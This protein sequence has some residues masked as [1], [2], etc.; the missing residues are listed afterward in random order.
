MSV[1]HPIVMIDTHNVSAV[2]PRASVKSFSI[3]Q[4]RQRRSCAAPMYVLVPRLLW[5]E[6]LEVFTSTRNCVQEKQ[7]NYGYM[8]GWQIVYAL[9]Q[10]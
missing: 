3:T 6:I 8:R 7:K 1:A 2:Q 4:L 5:L 9:L 10:L